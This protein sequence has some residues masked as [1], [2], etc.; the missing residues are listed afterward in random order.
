MDSSSDGTK[1]ARL[2]AVVVILSLVLAGLIFVHFNQ[3]TQMLEMEQVLREEKDS[4]AKELSGIIFQ[5]DTLKN[6]SDSMSVEIEEQQEKIQD[7][8]DIKATNAHKIRVYKRELGTLRDVM[9]SYI[10]QVDSLNT[11]NQLL[12]AENQEVR[13]QLKNAEDSNQELSKIKNEL[14]SKVEIAS[15]LQAKNISAEPLNSKGKFKDKTEKV[16]KIKVCLT[17]R[18]NPIAEAGEKEVFLRIIRPDDIVVTT[19]I[20]NVFPVSDEKQLVYSASR[21]V[22]YMNQDVDMCIFWTNDKLLIPGVYRI[23]LYLGP[24]L[25]GTSSITLK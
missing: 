19:S 24:N 9:K 6:S 17:L 25:I 13:S 20:D 12:T 1:T 7:L 21:S 8:L 2:I 18:E 23:E 4:L 16:E 10:R 14:D 5:Y 11:K 15:V 3:R 22:E